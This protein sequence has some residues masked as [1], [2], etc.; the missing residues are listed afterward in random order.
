M[1]KLRNIASVIARNGVRPFTP[2]IPSKYNG[3]TVRHHRLTDFFLPAEQP[4]DKDYKE[5]LVE[6]VR[7]A[8]D[9]GDKVVVVGGG[10]GV[11]AVHAALKSRHYPDCRSEKVTVYECSGERVEVCRGTFELNDVDVDL[12]E[13]AV[14]VV[15]KQVGDTSQARYVHPTDLP[16]CDVL[17]LDCEGAEVEILRELSVCPE[18]VVVETHGEFDASTE[19][20]KQ[21]LDEEGYE[22]IVE[23]DDAEYTDDNVLTAEYRGENK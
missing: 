2:R 7:E 11:T 23:R 9:A 15:K 18:I 16:K 14:G 19:K 12:R 22:I 20:V 17:E 5:N 6:A 13:A 4:N 10:F 8:V 1:S 3:I 21:V